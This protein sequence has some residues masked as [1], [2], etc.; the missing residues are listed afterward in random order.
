MCSGVSVMKGN[1]C[2]TVMASIM[3]SRP[4]ISEKTPCDQGI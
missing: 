1:A 2:C 3:K 4:D